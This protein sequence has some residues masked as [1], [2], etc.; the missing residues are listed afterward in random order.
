MKAVICHRILNVLG[1]HKQQQV[2]VVVVITFIIL[3]K[4]TDVELIK[5]LLAF[6]V[7]QRHITMFQREINLTRRSSDV[8]KDMT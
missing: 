5:K 4:P 8:A 1:L 7:T 6:Y 3:G 2:T